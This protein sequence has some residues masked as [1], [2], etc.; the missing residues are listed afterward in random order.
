MARSEGRSPLQALRET[1]KSTMSWYPRQLSAV[2]FVMSIALSSQ[3]PAASERVWGILKGASSSGKTA[4]IKPL[5]NLPCV[6]ALDKI[7]A[8][9]MVSG[10]VD[11]D[12]PT[13]EFSLLPD[14]D[15][16]L[17][18]FKEFSSLL[19]TNPR[20]VSELMGQLRAAFDG[21]LS[22][23][24]GTGQKSFKSKFGML[25][26]SVPTPIEE[27]MCGEDQLGTR[28][29]HCSLDFSPEE[30]DALDS[31]ALRV[32]SSQGSWEKKL[33]LDVAK[34]LSQ[35]IKFTRS[36]FPHE[37]SVPP[38]PQ[39]H[40][41]AILTL[42]RVVVGARTIPLRWGSR[43]PVIQKPERASRFG[44]QLQW[45]GWSRAC[46]DCRDAWDTTDLAFL[47][48]V[49]RDT[50]SRD[51]LLA[52]EALVSSPGGLT[53]AQLNA[54]LHRDSEKD[55]RLLLSQYVVN[56]LAQPLPT[57]PGPSTQ[58]L[59]WGLSKKMKEALDNLPPIA[60]T[61]LVGTQ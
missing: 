3:W 27:F 11:P 57:V 28:F 36:R 41:E 7:S 38:L 30:A 43:N 42:A 33:N 18:I 46:L 49:A 9:A 16:K 5:L 50:L 10:L 55:C 15:G 40:H 13:K 24:F 59:R 34:A 54:Q 58:P 53:T 44:K 48:K 60:Y 52:F 35:A 1:Y 37:T 61:T 19:N 45:L 22:A 32:A 21:G 20:D 23:A 12:N 6:K 51:S 29:L 56:G 39:D 4:I 25:L 8:K 31:H 47:S 17:V 26:L 14:I 2:D